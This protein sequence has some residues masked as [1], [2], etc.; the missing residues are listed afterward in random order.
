MPKWIDGE[1]FMENVHNYLMKKLKKIH[2]DTEIKRELNAIYL[3]VSTILQQQPEMSKSDLMTA[4]YSGQK[5]TS[6]KYHAKEINRLMD[7]MPEYRTCMVGVNADIK[8]LKG[9]LETIYDGFV[10]WLSYWETESVYHGW[11]WSDEANAKMMRPQKALTDGL[12]HKWIE[13]YAMC[14]KAL[15]ER[16]EE[17]EGE[18]A[19]Y[20]PSEEG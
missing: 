16:M 15:G 8:K 17:E 10:F 13:M 18:K 11:L 6:F 2:G 12:T 1:K 14:L 20:S 7:D 5:D 19:E 9:L 3:A 4:L